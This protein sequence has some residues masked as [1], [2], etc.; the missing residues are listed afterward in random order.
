MVS[1]SS[2]IRNPQF[3]VPYAL[4]HLICVPR[5]FSVVTEGESRGRENKREEERESG[6]TLLPLFTYR[7]EGRSKKT[8]WNINKKVDEEI[9][10]K[11]LR[12]E[13]KSKNENE[14]DKD[15]NRK[16]GENQQKKRN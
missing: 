4:A 10:K 8:K 1:L 16:E 5:L 14:K 13:N 11:K 3:T 9:T 12:R 6:R 2:H 7:T 15:E